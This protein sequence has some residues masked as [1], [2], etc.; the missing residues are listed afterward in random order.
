MI[1]AGVAVAGTCG[2]LVCGGVSLWYSWYCCRGIILAGIA[3]CRGD[4]LWETAA[5]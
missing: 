5:C 1:L 2:Y 3:G 4:Q